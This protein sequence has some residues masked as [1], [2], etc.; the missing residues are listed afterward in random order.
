MGGP[1][2]A[3]PR[4]T[5]GSPVWMGTRHVAYAPRGASG[6]VARRGMRDSGASEREGGGGCLWPELPA[7]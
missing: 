1:P 4:G 3:D 5:V 7:R 2:A 6:I